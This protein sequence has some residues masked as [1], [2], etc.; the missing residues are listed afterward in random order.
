MLH[1]GGVRFD[2]KRHASRVAPVAIGVLVLLFSVVLVVIDISQPD[3]LAWLDRHPWSSQMVSNVVVVLATY[4][5]VDR[6]VVARDKSR[7]R[8]ASSTCVESFADALA[9]F[10]ARS[11]VDWLSDP[12]P[13]FPISERHLKSCLEAVEGLNDAASGLLAIAPTNPETAAFVDYV[14]EVRRT[15]QDWRAAVE[16]ELV[17]EPEDWGRLSP[18]ARR[19]RFHD[20]R[21]VHV[22]C[23]SACF[24]NLSEKVDAYLRDGYHM[25]AFF[26][27]DT[28]DSLNYAYSSDWETDEWD[29]LWG[30]LKVATW[31][32]Y[33]SV[34]GIDVDASSFHG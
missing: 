25:G 31:R 22:E 27:E 10:L 20:S 19:Q 24:G 11:E 33:W 16:K 9:Y 21:F 1:D 28:E 7:W 34:W 15:T 14:L 23:L 6:I 3:G 8:E 5:I 30:P 12:R 18:A 26:E 2:L 29:S 13:V 4:L 17:A 32:V